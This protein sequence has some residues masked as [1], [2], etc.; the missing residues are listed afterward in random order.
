[1]E[2]LCIILIEVIIQMKN[3]IVNGITS[4]Y[5]LANENGEVFNIEGH[6]LSY[7]RSW[8][9]YDR[10]RLNRDIPRNLYSV[11]RIIAETFLGNQHNMPIVNH[12]DNIRYNNKVSNL[13][14]CTNSHNQLQRFKS[15][16]KGTKRVPIEQLDLKTGLVIKEWGSAIDVKKE[17]NIANQN[18][19]K[20]CKGLRNHAGGY[21]WRYKEDN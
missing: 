8:N 6:R 1:M 4:K 20:V 7:Y 18:I 16:Y 17:L 11:H 2:N 5:Y 13:E 9:E 19:Q 12:K 15:G 10:V 3:I 14:W 21:G